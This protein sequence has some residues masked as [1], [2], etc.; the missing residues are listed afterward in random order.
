MSHN[1]WIHRLA[2]ITIVAPLIGTSVKPNQ[3]TTL[4]LTTGIGAAGLLAVGEPPWQ[5]IGAGAF[6][7]AMLL[8]R[9]DG[10]YARL[11]GQTSPGGH[12]YDLIADAL[13]NALVFVG[14]G[15]GLR[16]GDYGSQAV[17]MG[18][19]AGVAIGAILWLVIRI[20]Q[21]EGPRAAE[22]GSFLGFD[23]DDAMIIVPLCIWFNASQGLLL[24]AAAGTPVFAIFFYWFFRRKRAA[25]RAV[26]REG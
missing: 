18:L 26:G 16:G 4:R 12:T 6:L 3:L 8:D 15:I 2:R 21:L 5:H 19:M 11:T 9:A 14:L 1:T 24:V 23:P 10:D 13:C 22:L 20:E 7:L 25:I 17:L